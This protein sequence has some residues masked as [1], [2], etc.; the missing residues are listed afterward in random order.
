MATFTSSLKSKLIYVF[1]IDDERHRDCLK[2]GETTL[3]EDD[4]SNLFDNTE[5]L[6]KAAHKRIRQY[7]G[8]RLSAAAYGNQH[9]C[10]EWHDS[11]LQRQAGAQGVGAFGHPKEGV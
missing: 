1:A 8:H 9:L 11:F 4:G 6:Q 2:I 7:S 3:E 5:A 10:A